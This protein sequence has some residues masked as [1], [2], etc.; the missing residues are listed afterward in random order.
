MKARPILLSAI[1]FSL[2]MLQ[3][4]FAALPRYEIIDLGTLDGTYSGAHAINDIGQVVGISGSPD[5]AFLWDSST[6]MID[7]GTLPGQS[8]SCAFG[9]NDEGQ[10]VGDTTGIIYDFIAF[11][12]DSDKGMRYLDGIGTRESTAF[13]INN[14]GQVVGEAGYAFL[15]HP[16]DGV[17]DLGSLAKSGSSWAHA[18]NEVTQVVGASHHVSG[19]AHAFIWDSIKGMRDLGTL[20]GD[21]S[22]AYGI[23]NH[24]QVVG[25]SQYEPYNDNYHAF[26]WD[27]NDG[28][29]DLNSSF[30]FG[31]DESVAYAINDA[32]QIVGCLNPWGPSVA[33]YLDNDNGMIK[34]EDLIPSN[35][36]WKGLRFAFD[37]NN[38]G[39]IVGQGITNSGK[40][41]AFLMTPLPSKIIYVDDNADGANDGSSWADA[42]NYL[43]DALTAAWSGDEIR[44]AQGV[45]KPDQGAGITP[46][47][48]EATFQLI[49]GVTIKGSY[50]GYGTPDPNARDIDLY[51][52]ILSGD[53][54]GNDVTG[55]WYTKR[56]NGYHV[57][58]GSGTAPSA[59]IQGFIIAHGNAYDPDNPVTNGGG[60]L[61]E[62][63]SP[64]IMDCTFSNNSRGGIYNYKSSPK[65]TDCTFSNNSA[66]EG[67]GMYN[68]E[69]SPTMISCTFSN[70]SAGSGGGMRNWFCDDL[71]IIDCTFSGNFVGADCQ[72]GGMSNA[73]SH[74][75]LINCSFIGN[76]TDKDSDG[77]AMVNWHS[78]PNLTN[79]TFTGNS[80]EKAGG[81][82]NRYSNPILDNCA[83]SSNYAERSS[84]GMY[85][86]ECN[87]TLVNCIFKYNEAGY[88]GG[89]MYNYGSSPI[90]SNC[91]FGGN[92]S[93][94]QGGGMYNQESSLEC[95]PELTNCI[96]S[97]NRSDSVGGGMSNE[98]SAPKLINCSFSGNS[99][100]RG[101]GMFNSNGT[102]KLTNCLFTGNYASLHTGN[103][104]YSSFSKGVL[105]N[106]ILWGDI[107]Q[108]VCITGYTVLISYSNIQGGWPGEGN[109]DA[110]PFFTESGY[111]ADTNDSNIIV[112]PNDPSAIW[113]D[114]DYHLLPGSPCIDTGDPNFVAEPNETDLDGRPRVIGGRI[115]MGAYETPILAEARILPR[116]INLAS[117]G[118][119]I[120][121]YIRLLEGYNVTDIEPSSVFLE[122]QIKAEQFS[123][124]EHK[125]VAT[126]TF[127]RENVQS[128]LNVGDTELVITCQLTDGTYF[129]ATD[130]IKVTDKGGGKSAK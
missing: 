116:T 79:C 125:Q 68:N 121:C 64:T 1:V 80:A 18:I 129:E 15:W 60:M 23:N 44:V 45:Y 51:E 91:T 86:L 53:L 36:I 94:D 100:L 70:N 35:S 28:M 67:G 115:D 93:G 34:L 106:C 120:T 62:N 119:W 38:S 112:E 128:I 39:Q 12:W 58:T 9:I 92:K 40:T 118:N 117:K 65:I 19:P 72:G 16:E 29:I 98:D 48:R 89:G 10:V 97:G 124:D 26:L 63:G 41:L 42:F 46:G 7:L 30:A 114:G 11:I 73:Y 111:W 55:D 61:N 32:G 6:G 59:V 54:D 85:N 4:T 126:A 49:N 102:P 50:A 33:F 78:N 17:I 43:Q 52:T 20:G 103:G 95:N 57:V 71:M 81:M 99:A 37:I 105:S 31:I 25:R 27:K 76:S 2:L 82:Y 66:S 108:D 87:P 122:K 127:D 113:V 130:V 13:D 5:H 69:S 74:P 8:H 101:G 88:R 24:G 3:L 83:F 22:V 96:F 84:G 107:L 110:D 21:V 47:D 104:I 14:R 56:E 75:T 123:V 109:I 77:G 90:L